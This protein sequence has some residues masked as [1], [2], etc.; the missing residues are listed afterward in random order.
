MITKIEI[1]DC[2][3]F[4]EQGSFLSDLKEVNFIYGANG[5]GKTTISNV[6]A[7]LENFSDC[8]I[9][10][11]SNIPL[12]TFVYNRTFVDENF[13]RSRNLKGVFTLGKEETNAKIEIEKKKIEINENLS[14]DTDRD[15]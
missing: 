1:K 14:N 10:W 12:K 4:D 2:A 15:G 11:K 5:S 3:S 7:D 8:T 9:E 6:I 13:G